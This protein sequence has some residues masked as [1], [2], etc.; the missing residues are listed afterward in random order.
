MGLP[1][2]ASKQCAAAIDAVPGWDFLTAGAVSEYVVEIDSL[3]SEPKRAE[4]VGASARRRILAVYSW[5]AHLSRIDRYLD[6]Q[7]VSNY[8]DETP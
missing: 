2:V 7:G 6:S 1:V 5:D 4:S 3:L 8:A